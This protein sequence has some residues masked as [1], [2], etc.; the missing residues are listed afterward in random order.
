M[1]GC[2][3]TN[4]AYFVCVLIEHVK[5]RFRVVAKAVLEGWRLLCLVSVNQSALFHEK[6]PEGG[7]DRRV[8]PYPHHIPVHVFFCNQEREVGRRTCSYQ[9]SR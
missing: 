7:V 8:R 3:Q 1:N 6:I 2:V 5:P 4:F 9:L